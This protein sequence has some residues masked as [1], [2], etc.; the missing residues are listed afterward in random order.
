[1]VSPY[2]NMQKNKIIKRQR[3]AIDMT[4]NFHNQYDYRNSNKKTHFTVISL[5]KIMFSNSV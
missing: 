5:K 4:V 1:M 2:T 3:D